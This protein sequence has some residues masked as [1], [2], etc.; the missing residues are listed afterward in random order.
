M[1]IALFTDTYLP[2]VNG[3]SRT[4]ARLVDHATARGHDV[5]LVTPRDRDRDG[6]RAFL[7]LASMRVPFYPELRLAVPMDPWSARRL[8]AYRPDVV[9]VAT[10]FTTGWSGLTYARGKRVPVI[11]SFHTDLPAY[12]T[13]YGFGGLE[14]AAWSWLRSFHADARTTLCPSWATLRQLREQEFL[15]DLRVW[16]RGVDAEAFRPAH[17]SVDVRARLAPG[18]HHILLY[19]GRLAPEKRVG[20]L[21]EAFAAVR[22]RRPG[23][24]LVIVGDGPV[25]DELTAAAPEGVTFTGFLSG[26]ELARA[27][28]AADVFTFPSDTET[29]GNVVLE[30]MASGLPVVAPDRGGVQDSVA[31]DETGVLVEPGSAEAFAAGILEILDDPVRAAR[32]R[33]GARSVAEGKSWDGILDEVLDVYAE[34]ATAAPARVA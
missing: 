10:E 1:R 22:E 4:L 32:M 7:E 29:F 27:Y 24:A 25:R 31:P 20:V 12:L 2:Q 34:A 11:S 18:A 5:A 28:A 21:L 30:A 3:V 23:T 9:H 14:Q 13:G 8:D 33:V 6:R 19:V 26:I 16:S 15:G 17:R